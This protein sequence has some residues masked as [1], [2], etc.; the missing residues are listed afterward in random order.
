MSVSHIGNGKTSASGSKLGPSLSEV[1][2]NPR[3]TH[4][5]CCGGIIFQFVP[6]LFSL[7]TSKS[8]FLSKKGYYAESESSQENQ[9]TWRKQSL[10]PR[11]ADLF[12]FFYSFWL[13]AL[14]ILYFLSQLTFAFLS[15]LALQFKTEQGQHILKNPLV[16]ASLVEKVGFD[17]GDTLF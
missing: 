16:I 15:F 14:I 11:Y 4:G 7:Y 2:E 17:F 12:Y 5:G 6:L 1:A 9:T 10:P 3:N 13:V 8:F